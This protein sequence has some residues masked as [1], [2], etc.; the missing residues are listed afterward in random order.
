MT[1]ILSPY[2]LGAP[3]WK[4]VVSY[5]ADP[6]GVRDS[7]AAINAA[8]AA[9]VNNSS[10]PAGSIPPLGGV[11]YFPPGLYN[12]TA[13][14]NWKLNGLVVRGDGYNSTT[15]QQNTANTP[16]VQVAGHGQEISGL[17]L[18]YATAQTSG[19][20]SAIAMT[21]GDDTVGSCF[22]SSFHDLQIQG[23]S[24][25]MG[26]DPS[27]ATAAGLFS[28]AFTDITLNLW[29]VSAIKFIANNGGGLNNC[30]GCAFTN[31]YM[32][33]TDI[34]H[35]QQSCTSFPVL[36]KSWDEFVFNQLNIEHCTL[37]NQDALS[38][39]LCRNAVINSLHTESLTLNGNGTGLVGCITA[40][41][42]VVNGL[43]ALH[44]VYAGS[45]SNSVARFGTGAGTLTV[46]GFHEQNCTVTT[47]S[48]P[49]VDFGSVANC[50]AQFTGSLGT[51]TTVN[52]V[53]ATTGDYLHLGYPQTGS[54][55]LSSGTATISNTAVTAASVIMLTDT[56]NGA[57]LGILSV[58]TV[59]AGVSFVVNSS[60]AADGGTFAYLLM[61]TG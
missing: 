33:N 49:L 11:A 12:I 25:L 45:A 3:S 56:A 42:V 60:N 4:N 32:A 9:A 13:A 30:T 40:N 37:T 22:M 34:N 17:T 5:G 59:T 26:I 15:I 61:P 35:V 43:R 47:P 14:L 16:I 39:S 29:S 46:N 52:T 58:G 24:V 28:C 48:H 50:T 44:N 19:Q 6:T 23:G 27:I 18:A 41:S 20:T 53:N 55:T 54:G 57:N 36:M 21:F 38:I 10:G 1:S 8:V 7:T 2:A 31:I 51:Q